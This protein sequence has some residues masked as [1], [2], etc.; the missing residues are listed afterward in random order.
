MGLLNTRHFLIVIFL[1][2]CKCGFSQSQSTAYLTYIDNYHQL[3]I[4]QQQEYRIP[5]SITLAQGLLESGAGLSDFVKRSNNHFGIKCSDWTGERIYHDDDEKGECFRKY[6]HVIQSYEDHSLFLKNRKRYASLFELEPTDYEGWAFGLKKA[7]YATDPSYAYKLISIIENYNLHR[8]DFEKYNEK[9]TGVEKTDAIATT[10]NKKES[11]QLPMGNVDVQVTHAIYRV[12]GVKFVIAQPGD[13]YA[14]IADEFDIP[15]NRL[16]AYN[17]LLNDSGLEEGT[18]VFIGKKKNK[19]PS[20]YE[21][22]RVVAGESMYSIS[23][24]YGIRVVKLYDLN[25]MPYTKGA[26]IGLVLKLR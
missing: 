13:N 1:L 16:L 20:G 12:N 18:R 14:L 2:L 22:H 23:Q 21:S 15:V 4:R 24:D 9:R 11:K 19:A 7:G 5:A 6:D 26:E 10:K 8:F 3:A 25:D 17:D